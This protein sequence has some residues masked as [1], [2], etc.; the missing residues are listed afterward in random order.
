MHV[1]YEVVYLST[2]C[3]KTCRPVETREKMKTGSVIRRKRE[4]SERKV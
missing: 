3:Q 4:R 1:F 2:Q